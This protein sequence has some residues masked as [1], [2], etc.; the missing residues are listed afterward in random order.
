MSLSSSQLE[1]VRNLFLTC[2]TDVIYYQ[3]S[4]DIQA[5]GI[6]ARYYTSKYVDDCRMGDP[7][8][9][10]NVALTRVA[11]AYSAWLNG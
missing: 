3:E 4:P 10:F 7:D 2:T 9:D 5:T 11:N 1:A 6:P 8:A